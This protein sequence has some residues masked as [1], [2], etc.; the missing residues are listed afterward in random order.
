MAG[1]VTLTDSTWEDE[2]REQAAMLLVSTGEGERSDFNVA[3]KKAAA[4]HRGPILFVQINPSD[5]P[6]AG[7]RFEFAGRPV[8]LA[9]HRGEVLTRRTR[10]WGS[11]VPLTIELLQKAVE[12][13]RAM[14]AAPPPP[15]EPL[16]ENNVVADMKFDSKPVIVTDATF[17]QEV[18]DYP[19]PV[20]VDFW[21]EWCG[22]CRMVAP[23]LEKLA[24]EFAG[25]IRIAKV[26][27]DQN[28]GLSETFRIMSIPTI[29]AFKEKHLVFNQAGAF[30]EA[31]FRQLIEQV[32][33]LEIPAHDHEHDHE[34]D[35]GPTS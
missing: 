8:L 21:A 33:A 31:A 11:D 30:P 12:E 9:W 35:H 16:K 6:Q 14:P 4:E 34:H 26:D 25:K 10:P 17:Q 32:I 27:V 28:R 7:A 1:I 2:L 13:Q 5:S 19:L 22:P 24:A 18:V 3:F 20:L 29:M 15:P 23:I